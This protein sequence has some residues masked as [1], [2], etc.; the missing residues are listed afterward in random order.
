MLENSL[1]VIIVDDELNARINLEHLIKTYC[2]Q[3]KVVNSA[4]NAVE[5]AAI[6]NYIKPDVVFLDISMPQIN[7]FELLGMLDS[8]PSIVFVT[9]HERYAIR[10]IKTS[11]LDF[12]LKPVNIDELIKVETKLLQLNSLLK[13]H[14]IQET[15]NS[16]VK[17]FV[18]MLEKKQEVKKIALPDLHGF[19]ILDIED[20][21][22]LEGENNYTVFYTLGKKHIVSKTLKEYEE[23]LLDS[24]FMRIHKSSI[25]N[26]KHL[27]QYSVKE[28][29]VIMSD[30][31]TLSISRR[32]ATE[33][34]DKA[35]QYIA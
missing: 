4:S 23:L 5:A 12:L 14:N 8:I 16:I 22:Y 35:K 34:F 21:M 17:D 1:S 3:L 11:A 26:M 20:I 10:A 27:K 15:Y 28:M 2:P 32:R 7:G 13:K 18:S 19:N 9:A 25:I 30:K 24:G 31:K 33:F 6:I 29:E